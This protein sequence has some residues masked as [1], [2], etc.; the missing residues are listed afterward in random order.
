MTYAMERQEPA[1][2]LRDMKKPTCI[3]LFVLEEPELLE[4]DDETF[5]ALSRFRGNKQ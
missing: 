3:V 1:V 5:H 2:V 4:D